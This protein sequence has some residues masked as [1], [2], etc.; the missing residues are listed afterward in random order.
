[1]TTRLCK[2]ALVA[3]A[4]AAWCSAGCYTRSQAQTDG[5]HGKSRAEIEAQ[6]GSPQAVQAIQGGSILHWAHTRRWRT[7]PSASAEGSAEGSA[8]GRVSVDN[9]DEAGVTG[10]FTLGPDGA[11]AELSVTV[12]EISVSAEAEA[13]AEVEARASAGEV[14]ERTT[15]AEV[16]VDAA[17]LITG[18]SAGARRWGPPRNSNVRWGPILGLHV[19]LGRLDSTRIALP[20]G[21]VYLGG[22][23]GPDR[24][25]VGTF[26]MVSGRDEGGGAMGM[27]WGFE[28]MWWPIERLSV[29]AGP[30]M[31]LDWKPGFENRSFGVAA[32]GGASY[33]LVRRGQFVLDLRTDLT[34]HRKSAFG[35]LGVG[36]NL[37]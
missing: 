25:L 34:A 20:S 18:V 24:A 37:Q 9:L 30:A 36:V 26:S 3:A 19:G 29:Q 1:M 11:E 22:M 31:V 23:L 10:E 15:A 33:A 14:R 27:S 12:P 5:W 35:T 28:G 4:G 7:S 17:G 6:W 21:G 2:F 16:T 13:E 8:G 32:S